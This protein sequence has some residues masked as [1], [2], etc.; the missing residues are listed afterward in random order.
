MWDWRVRARSSGPAIELAVAV[1]AFVPAISHRCCRRADCRSA[2][3]RLR[4]RTGADLQKPPFT[5]EVFLAR[6]AASTNNSRARETVWKEYGHRAP[7]SG[8]RLGDAA[9]PSPHHRLRCGT[10][11]SASSTS[12]THQVRSLRK[13]QPHR[14]V[15]VGARSRHLP[16]HH[17]PS[18][19]TTPRVLGAPP[20]PPPPPPSPPLIYPPPPPPPPLA[21]TPGGG[22]GSAAGAFRRMA[23][24]LAAWPTRLAGGA[25]T[26]SRTG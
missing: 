11:R 4:P 20:P 16:G 6:T 1:R 9:D 18:Q 2:G 12:S 23:A 8:R 7:V 13:R 5:E 10:T 21:P 24:V 22:G 25:R 17:R 26:M 19:P 3:Q 15:R 14:L